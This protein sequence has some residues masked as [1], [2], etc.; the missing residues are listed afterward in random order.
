MN[1]TTATTATMAHAPPNLEGSFSAALRNGELAIR[2][3]FK[4]TDPDHKACFGDQHFSLSTSFGKIF[5]WRII[6]DLHAEAYKLEQTLQKILAEK[7]P[8]WQNCR[9][10]PRSNSLFEPAYS[11][12]SFLIGPDKSHASPHLTI[13]TSDQWVAKELKAFIIQT[14]MLYSRWG[15][16][17]LPA[18]VTL[19][20]TV[21]AF[22]NSAETD[23]PRKENGMYDIC[24]PGDE[25]PSNLNGVLVEVWKGEHFISKATIGGFLSVGGRILALS[26]AHSFSPGQPITADT[27]QIDE[28]D[29]EFLV[30]DFNADDRGE[31]D[32][33]ISSLETSEH[34][35]LQS[36]WASSPSIVNVQHL[37]SPPSE[38]RT[39]IGRLEY[40]SR[41]YD[42]INPDFNGLDWAL[43]AITH[44][45]II[46]GNKPHDPQTDQDATDGRINVEI[47][48]NSHSIDTNIISSAI[49]ASAPNSLP[50]SVL[51]ANSGDIIPG[52]SG[53]WCFS[54]SSGEVLAMILGSCQSMNQCYL[55]K[56]EDIKADIETQLGSHVEVAPTVPLSRIVQP[57]ESRE[58]SRSR[59]SAAPDI[60]GAFEA[61]YSSGRD[62][63]VLSMCR[64]LR[65]HFPEYLI[66]HVDQST[67]DLPAFTGPDRAQWTLDEETD[68]F[69]SIR[70]RREATGI[71]NTESLKADFLFAKYKYLWN[72]TNFI[73]FVLTSERFRGDRT[74]NHFLLT[75]RDTTAVG[76]GLHPKARE[77][78]LAAGQ[79]TSRNSIKAWDFQD[80]YSANP[81]G[82]AES[83]MWNIVQPHSLDHLIMNNATKKE[84]TANINSFFASGE[85][86]KKFNLTWKR[87][88]LFHG[89]SGTG[90]TASL[91]AIMRMPVDKEHPVPSIYIKT[92][93]ANGVRQSGMRDMFSRAREI[94]P[95]LLV[96]ENLDSFMPEH[97]HA[98]LTELDSEQNDGI[99]VI[100][101][102]RSLQELDPTIRNHPGRFDLK[103][104]FK[105]PGFDERLSFA[106][107]WKSK[108]DENH[109]VDLPEDACRFVAELTDGVN[110][111][112]LKDVFSPLLFYSNAPT[113]S[114]CG[115]N[116]VSEAGQHS[117]DTSKDDTTALQPRQ[118]TFK[119]VTMPQSLQD[120]HVVKF[121]HQQ[122]TILLEN[123]DSDPDAFS[124]S[125][126][127][128]PDQPKIASSPA[129]L[130]MRFRHRANCRGQPEPNPAA[131]EDACPGCTKEAVMAITT[132]ESHISHRYISNKISEPPATSSIH[133]DAS[134]GR[135]MA[136][137]S[138]HS[139]AGASAAV[140]E[141]G[142]ASAA[143]ESGDN[144]ESNPTDRTR[145]PSCGCKKNEDTEPCATPSAKLYR[146]PVRDAPEREFLQSPQ[147]RPAP[148]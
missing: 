55:L 78:C 114:E 89:P 91:K 135:R 69:A 73:L 13:V 47:V 66:N 125:S 45:R 85:L 52:D 65:D 67:C 17:R 95:C 37:P 2:Q 28:S 75:P 138:S 51:V 50:H 46:L 133:P 116:A 105:L 5:G 128:P 12:Q 142:D 109:L 147:F 4:K 117:R 101:S 139:A 129:D 130:R 98:F 43:I 61:L 74:E 39:T 97:R 124:L 44:P 93:G 34:C 29:L 110:Y 126:A 15:C 141:S 60:L 57:V 104:E 22:Q 92:T 27:F 94:A 26:T 87:G 123:M 100:G 49:F 58:K 14:Q 54:R 140:S 145:C 148:E 120:N 90:K 56:M 19:T 41:G 88:I 134:L 24:I 7:P 31:V 111:A 143:P 115:S 20:S 64:I 32:V 107:Q 40:I 72:G 38:K 8:C 146:T 118:E 96:I 33:S 86:F 36:D 23:E 53:S 70:Y 132:D 127:H 136:N 83:D 63:S 112:H 76:S 48:T 6:G 106:K 3:R 80:P 131:A 137:H 16:F 10:G 121:L 108:L 71:T 79:Y 9:P 1:N 103:Y 11:L 68:N 18:Q 62:F 42:T 102:T 119:K 122:V 82:G 84:L 25:V 21:S 30:D 113:E 35:C 144:G 59:I 81:L 99:L 77:L